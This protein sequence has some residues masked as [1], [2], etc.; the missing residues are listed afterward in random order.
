MTAEVATRLQFYIITNIRFKKS[1]CVFRVITLY[2]QNFT[3]ICCSLSASDFYS[4]FTKK[5]VQGPRILEVFEHE[6]FEGF[7]AIFHRTELA[8]LDG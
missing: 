5:L 4:H 6:V 8:F 7:S 1:K 2:K 3:L